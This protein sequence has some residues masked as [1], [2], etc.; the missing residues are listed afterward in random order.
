VTSDAAAPARGRLV[1]FF[2]GLLLGCA[3]WAAFVFF[4]PAPPT[5][6]K[7]ARTL[8][9]GS[10]VGE[11]PTLPEAIGNADPGDTI[12][13]APG[14]YPEKIALRPGLTICSVRPRAAIIAGGI[15]ADLIESGTLRELTVG[16]AGIQLN[17]SNLQIDGIETS[18]EV[19]FTGISSGSLHGSKIASSV[20]IRDA[21]SPD[22][23]VNF[24][25][26]DIE[27]NSTGT[28]KL[29]GNAIQ[30][31]LFLPSA[32]PPALSADLLKHNLFSARK[33]IQLIN[34]AGV[35]K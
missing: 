31:V 10:A 27:F 30:G 11:Y 22:I 34:P 13:V 19:R 3:A 28:M 9:V 35:P 24:I 16:D 14:T 4:R 12:E 25:G 20:K 15:V 5:V 17:S 7:A 26:G 2:A 32:L 29:D 1:F 8:H 21:A 6:P 18:G 33:P 23:S